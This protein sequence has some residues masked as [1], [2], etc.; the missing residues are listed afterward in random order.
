MSKEM[1]AAIVGAVIAGIFGLVAACIGGPLVL[2]FIGDAGDDHVSSP[3][4]TSQAYTS[5][6]RDAPG[7]VAQ[8]ATPEPTTS[9]PVPQVTPT[10]V[11][12]RNPSGPVS[13]GTR[14]LADDFSLL[15][16]DGFDTYGDKIGVTLVVQNV[17]GR[18]HLFR[19][20]CAA[21]GLKDDL[22]NVYRSQGEGSEEYYVT[23]QLELAPGEAVVLEP[24]NTWA[25]ASNTYIPRFVGPI[26]PQ[27]H[28]L[29][30]LINGLGP[31]NGVEAEIDL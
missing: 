7:P 8:A 17:G 28:T 22:N 24:A 20:Q 16:E 6:S 29:T 14:I 9:V 19:Y 18:T 23:R 25:W 26:A 5:T 10:P 2:R 27:A 21:L 11:G 15:V 1:R 31:F 12:I 30:V 4:P 13:A 3:S